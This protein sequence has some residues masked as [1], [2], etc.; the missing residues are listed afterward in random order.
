MLWSRDAKIS[1]YTMSQFVLD[2]WRD[3]ALSLFAS[4]KNLGGTK[5]KK[6][7]HFD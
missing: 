6:C 7:R 5:M 4:L 1:L 2:V 3:L